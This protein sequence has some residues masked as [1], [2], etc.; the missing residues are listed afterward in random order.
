[1]FCASGRSPPRSGRSPP[2]MGGSPPRLGRSPSRLG[3]SPQRLGRSPPRLPR[4]PH[5]LTRSPPR[6]TRSPPRLPRSPPRLN[7][8]PTRLNRS[9]LRPGRSPIRLARSPQ[10]PDFERAPSF[11]MQPGRATQSRFADRRQPPAEKT[12]WIGQV[13]TKLST[14]DIVKILCNT[15]VAHNMRICIG[16]ARCWLLNRALLSDNEAYAI[17]QLVH[18]NT[19]HNN[20]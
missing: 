13:Y 19:M 14:Q 6:L 7:R 2:R 5:R 10:R 18:R 9:P 3:R 11:G 20:P 16:C 12:L 4:S 8:S 1:M 15:S 17:H